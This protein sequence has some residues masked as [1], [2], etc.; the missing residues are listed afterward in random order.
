MHDETATTQAPR[1]TDLD[2]AHVERDRPDKI[3][4][5]PSARTS[6]PNAWVC[7]FLRAI[8]DD[9]RLGLPVEVPDAVNRCAA[10]GE[11][12][13]QSLRQQELVCLTSAHVNCP[14]YLRGSV[15][16]GPTT[17][18]GS[19]DHRS[20]RPAIAGSVVVLV[21]AFLLSIA[22]VVANGGLTLT[23]AESAPS[24]SPS[25]NGARRAR[26]RRSRPRPRPPAP[27]P[28][29]TARRPRPPTP[30]P[31]PAPPTPTPHRHTAADA[32]AH[33]AGHPGR[34]RRL[35]A[36]SDREPDEAPEP[37]P[38]QG[39]V[40]R[41]PDPVGRQPVQHRQ[42]LRCLR[43]APSRPGTRGPTPG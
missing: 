24:A 31:T 18:S 36:R 32:R 17:S 3:R 42:L 2:D 5:G 8:G 21:V 37:V 16:S 35:S 20:S 19:R 41:L 12:V 11:S 1:I 33:P 10:L 13:P 15:A 29:P 27:T 6:S 30:T 22:F 7:P 23:A 39:E 26:D 28:A 38:G 40:L 25:G 9:G 4:P 43:S 34:D 14:R